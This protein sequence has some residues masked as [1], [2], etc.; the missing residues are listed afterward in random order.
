M[1]FP[2]NDHYNTKVILI[3]VFL[4]MV[5]E[6][7]QITMT[8]KQCSVKCVDVM[9]MRYLNYKQFRLRIQISKIKQFIKTKQ[10]KK[11]YGTLK[12]LQGALLLSGH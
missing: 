6:R 5:V 9:M 10:N 2:V 12:G 7:R 3:V 1:K 8:N 4:F 11:E